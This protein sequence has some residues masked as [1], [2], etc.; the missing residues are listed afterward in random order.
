M[1]CQFSDDF[2]F[3]VFC[4]C[5]TSVS[6]DQ[7]Y[8][9]NN[10]PKHMNHYEPVT[11]NLTLRTMPLIV[12]IQWLFSKGES[13]V[14]P[15]KQTLG[16]AAIIKLKSCDNSTSVSVCVCV[17]SQ[18]WHM[19]DG[20]RYTMLLSQSSFKTFVVSYWTES[21][22]AVDVIC[23]WKNKIK[24]NKRNSQDWQKW[25]LRSNIYGPVNYLT[26]QLTDT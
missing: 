16:N 20:I 19:I 9:K 5:E 2:D 10:I 4:V 23:A 18:R 7:G 25:G 3:W 15:C 1:F 12:S 26:S 13:K 17:Q 11:K 8:E 21:E 14:Q 24:Q 6:A 22:K